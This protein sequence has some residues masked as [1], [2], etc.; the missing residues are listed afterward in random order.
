LWQDKQV[1]DDHKHPYDVRD[2]G[3]FF[4]SIDE[5]KIWKKVRTDVD[6]QTGLAS[7]CESLQ[8]NTEIIACFSFDKASGDDRFFSDQISP[9]AELSVHAQTQTG[10]SPHQPWCKGIDDDGKATSDKT[11]V[12]W[13]FCSNEKPR[14]PGAGYNYNLRDMELAATVGAHADSVEQFVPYP[15]CGDVPINFTG[16]RAHADGGAIMYDSC[17]GLDD[18]KDC[19]LE[20]TTGVFLYA[21]FWPCVFVLL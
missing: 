2:A 6:I 19:F 16:N 3:Y 8:F 21:Y 1:H 4:G 9:D 17:Q 20:L 15:G 12:M 18:W 7:S 14:L 10:G 13:G 11:D 5:L